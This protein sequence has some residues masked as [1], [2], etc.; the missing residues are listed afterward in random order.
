MVAEEKEKIKQC[1]YV[2]ELESSLACP[3]EELHQNVH[4]HLSIG[5]I[6]LIM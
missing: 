3:P 1:S 5:S 4:H 6:L 2:F